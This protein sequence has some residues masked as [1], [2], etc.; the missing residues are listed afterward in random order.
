MDS[1]RSYKKNQIAPLRLSTRGRMR[2]NFYINDNSKNEMYDYKSNAVN[3]SKYNIITFLPKSLLFQFFRLANIYF[4]IV[5]IIQMIPIVSPL[6]PMT[7]VA[8]LVF[9]L[10]VS[11]FREGVEDFERHKY[12]NQLNNEKVIVYRDNEWVNSYSGKLLMGELVVIKKDDTFPADLVILDSSLNDGICFIET[13]S[14]DGEKTL[15]NKLASKFTSKK[16]NCDEIAG[17]WKQNFTVSGV[18]NCDGPNPDLYKFDGNLDVII[19]NEEIK[20]P[21]DNKN[22]LLKGNY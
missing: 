15:K 4:L 5:A 1:N 7:A 18:C 19:E 12:D 9:V 16:F 6:S 3:Q 13:S 21:I 10:L 11:M 22:L 20:C 14:L 8:P 17:H 2:Y